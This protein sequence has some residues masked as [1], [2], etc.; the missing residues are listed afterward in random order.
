MRPQAFPSQ[1]R[2]RCQ[3]VGWHWSPSKYVR[4]AA[5]GPTREIRGYFPYYLLFHP[6]LIDEME[7]LTIDYLL[8]CLPVV[9]HESYGDRVGTICFCQGRRLYYRLDADKKTST[10]CMRSGR[11]RAGI[12]GTHGTHG[13]TAPGEE[14]R[15]RGRY[16]LIEIRRPDPIFPKRA[17]HSIP[18]RPSLL[19]SPS[20]RRP[21]LH[22]MTLSSL[23]CVHRW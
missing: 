8:P 21:S 23:Y 11:R 7:R 19:F 15:D 1:S 6:M 3:K 10:P 22:L 14:T 18:G 13:P 9:H 20:V 4:G 5:T 12:H 2:A 17:P 16:L